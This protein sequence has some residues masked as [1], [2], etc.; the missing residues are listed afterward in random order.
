S[1][2]LLPRDMNRGHSPLYDRLGAKG[3][4]ATVREVLTQLLEASDNSAAD[5]LVRIA[6]GGVKLTAALRAMGIDGMTID[7]NEAEMARDLERVGVAKFDAD[8][9]DHATPAAMV[10]LLRKLWRGELVSAA[11]TAFVQEH[12]ARCYTGRA[13]LRAG[14]PPKTAVA[15]RTGT[16]GADWCANAVGVM[17]LPS[18]EHA[19]V[20][21]FV[22]GA[23]T[24]EAKEKLIAEVARAVW[25]DATRSR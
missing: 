14:V 11:S 16:C 12:M 5:A 13:R 24:T 18:G 4:R 2:T 6:G 23:A 21:A 15:D 3:G 1:V 7:R 20:A 9:R 8:P 22:A 25:A 19:L 10:E 17:T